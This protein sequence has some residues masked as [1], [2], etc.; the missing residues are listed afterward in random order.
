MKA[1]A[2]A[3]GVSLLAMPAI[4][5][6][7]TPVDAGKHV[8]EN[9]IVDGVVI[10]VHTAPNG[11][12]RLDLGGHYPDSKFMALIFPKDVAAFDG[13]NGYIGSRV[14]ISGAV[15]IYHG[16]PEITLTSEG[17]IQVINPA[18]NQKLRT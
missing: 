18:H 6:T 9:V 14:Q 16:E 10:D 8:G 12:I 7:V 5:A 13:V 17:Q 15:A 3:T 11:M 4:A 1:F 2:F